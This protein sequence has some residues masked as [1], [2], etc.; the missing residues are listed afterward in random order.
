M[1]GKGKGTRTRKRERGYVIRPVLQKLNGQ[2]SRHVKILWNSQL[3]HTPLIGGRCAAPYNPRNDPIT[4][5]G[6]SRDALIK[7]T[8]NAKAAQMIDG[9]PVTRISSHLACSWLV[10]QGVF[11][12]RD[13]V[14]CLDPKVVQVRHGGR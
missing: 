8:D 2:L 11:S 7:H 5:S 12:D 13:A 10:P 1:R 9:P 4:S 3:L 6:V 14:E